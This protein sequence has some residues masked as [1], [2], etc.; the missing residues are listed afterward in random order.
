MA[1]NLEKEQPIVATPISARE[2]VKVAR[3]MIEEERSGEQLG[4]KSKFDSLNIAMRKYFRFNNVNLWAGLSGSG[5][6]YLL[7][8]LSDDFI[9]PKINSGV[10]FGVLI[11][12][13]CFEM[14]SHNEVL[15]V[16]AKDLGLSYN[17]LLSSEYNKATGEYNTLTNEE[18]AQVDTWMEYY[19]NKNIIFYEIPTNM[20]VIYNTVLQ[21]YNH[22]NQGCKMDKHKRYINPKV[23]IIVNIDHTLLIEKLEE[24]DVMS[25]MANVGKV[26]IAIR[27][28][29]EAMVNLVGQLN[30]NI[31]D[32][33]RL[34]T[35]SLQF[36]KK[37]DIYAQGQ[38][39]NACD[40]VFVLTQPALL[41]L[42]Q[43]GP[44]KLPTIVMHE[45]RPLRVMHLL[46]LKARHGNIGSIWFLNNL[47]QGSIIPYDFNQAS[48]EIAD[49]FDEDEALSEI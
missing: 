42:E 7:G 43:Y 21:L 33:K 38:L 32:P 47:S 39:Y 4:V 22:Y 28:R 41:Q 8:L 11:A 27:K 10:N 46:L 31:E 34:L 49:N 2:A 3:Q 9:N 26:V 44:N 36:P 48:K 23:R 6:S 24:K 30:N 5:K 13:F 37:S 45:G 14:S 18:L 1:D 40:S 12:H 16:C 19:S 20:V 25:L 35:P 17:Y 15:R 29:C